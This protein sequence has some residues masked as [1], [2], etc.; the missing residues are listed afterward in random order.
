MQAMDVMTREVTTVSP[1]TTVQDA[2]RAMAARAVAALPVLDAD[3]LL[4]GIV[5]EADLLRGQVPAD[6]RLHLR[7]DASAADP[8]PRVVAEVMTS[9]VRTVGHR[10]DLSDVATLMVS[11]RLR[12]VPVMANGRM[13]GILG[14]RDLLR[15]LVR[16]DQSVRADVL[17]LLE[18]YTGEYG[19]FTVDV[20]AGAATVARTRGT[21]AVSPAAEH[22]ALDSLARTVPGVLT[23]EVRWAPDTTTTADPTTPREERP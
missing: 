4:V 17:G 7:R 19:A 10:D 14:R 13:V 22:R 15:T 6:P 2:G 1:A 20:Q 21:P 23:V 5:S 3:G 9:P 11:G 8:V 12:S 18:R 16:S